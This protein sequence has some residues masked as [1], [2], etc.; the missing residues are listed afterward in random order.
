MLVIQ[1]FEPFVIAIIYHGQLRGWQL[2]LVENVVQF[3]VRN[4]NDALTL[5]Q[6]AWYDESA[7]KPTHVLV[8]RFV[9]LVPWFQKNDVV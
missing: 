6:D 2:Q 5:L 3:E 8:E 1:R 9:G 4:G 7:I